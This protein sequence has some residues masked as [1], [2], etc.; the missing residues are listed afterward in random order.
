MDAFQFQDIGRQ[1]LMK[2]MYTLSK[3]NEYLNEL[4]GG[5]EDRGREFGSTI[6]KKTLEQDK[7]KAVVDNIISEYKGNGAESTAA[8]DTGINPQVNDEAVDNIAAQF[9]GKEKDSSPVD[10]KD[11][12]SIIAEFQKKNKEG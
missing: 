3:L 5:H 4:L 7:E 8:N 2:V 6:E 9:Q 10:N 11:I 1:K 12:D